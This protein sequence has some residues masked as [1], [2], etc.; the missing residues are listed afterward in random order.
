M[1]TRR[2]AQSRLPL[3]QV[4]RAE[5]CQGVQV[6]GGLQVDQPEVEPRGR[7]R[8]GGHLLADGAQ[9]SPDRSGTRLGHAEDGALRHHGEAARTQRMRHP[10][11]DQRL[12]KG[13][14]APGQMLTGR[15]VGV[16]ATEEVDRLHVGRARPV[17]QLGDAVF[18]QLRPGDVGSVRPGDSRQPLAG[19]ASG[20]ADHPAR[21]GGPR[22]G[23]LRDG[24]RRLQQARA[25][26][27]AHHGPAGR[28]LHRRAFG[29]AYQRQGAGNRQAAQQA[30]LFRTVRR[31][32]VVQQQ[33]LGGVRPQQ[34]GVQLRL[35]LSVQ[36]QG[37]EAQGGVA[38]V[39]R[40][41]VGPHLLV[42]LAEQPV[43]GLRIGAAK[44]VEAPI[45]DGRFRGS[46]AGD[47]DHV[48]GVAIAAAIGRL[49]EGGDQ[50][51]R[52]DLSFRKA[53]LQSACL[54]D[55]LGLPAD[56]MLAVR[57][58]V[59]ARVGVERDV[60]VDAQHQVAGIAVVEADAAPGALAAPL[61]ELP[62][63]VD[64]GPVRVLLHVAGQARPGRRP[65]ERDPHGPPRHGEDVGG[66][67]QV[68]KEDLQAAV[69][70]RG[71]GHVALLAAV[72]PEPLVHLD[73]EQVVGGG[74]LPQHA[75]D[76]AEVGAVLERLAEAGV[77]AFVEVALAHVVV[78]LEA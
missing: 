62:L 33:D 66:A 61:R 46:R 71:V 22:F 12:D 29:V 24:V 48:A 76:V 35:L 30:P 43:L 32:L 14:Q 10:V 5:P 21:T 68:V 56:G 25:P 51:P 1:L 55:E 34:A 57:T 7:A 63:L 53:G 39:E 60:G 20:L 65:Q 15:V 23:G 42:G 2:G 70:Q 11:R 18:G 45:D 49:F 40:V 50:L 52:L 13:D 75:L 73:V 58:V 78:G 27:G 72:R 74:V 38:A 19:Q 37:S 6:P 64:V 28:R 3:A 54:R 77:D 67:Q 47:L 44:V 4:A 17:G 59:P 36:V 8:L 9:R 41:V 31:C 26:A 16:L 69:E